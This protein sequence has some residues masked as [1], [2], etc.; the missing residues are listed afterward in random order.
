ML[1][2]SI[3]AAGL[4]L[5]CVACSRQPDDG[6]GHAPAKAATATIAVASTVPLPAPTLATSS[7]TPGGLLYFT[8]LLQRP[9][10]SSAFAALSGAEQ[11]PSWTSQGGTST[12]VERVQLSGRAQLLATACKP[13]D[14]PSERILLLYDEQTH[15]MAGLFARRKP[16]AREE[17]DS[18]DPANDDLIWLGAPDEPTRKLLQQSLYSPR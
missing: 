14:C 12:P 13:H 9:D 4:L 5:L 11:L 15:A 2:R 17:V 10:F 16:G 6:A 8:D 7:S 1:H 3:I 18:N